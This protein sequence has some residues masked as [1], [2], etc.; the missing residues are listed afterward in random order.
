MVAVSVGRHSASPSSARRNSPLINGIN[1]SSWRPSLGV[2]LTSTGRGTEQAPLVGRVRVRVMPGSTPLC[3]SVP[4]QV[5][6]FRVPSCYDQEET[7][8]R[9]A[10]RKRE[11]RKSIEPTRIRKGRKHC[12]LWQTFMC[13]VFASLSA[14][15]S[16]IRGCVSCFSW[17]QLS[18]TVYQQASQVTQTVKTVLQLASPTPVPIPWRW[19]RSS[20]PKWFGSGKGVTT[21]DPSRGTQLTNAG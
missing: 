8:A 14:T 9:L 6:R 4:V 10:K 7:L 20:T 15:M 17:R 11:T 3:L 18:L 2:I 12:L 21:K 16:L 5:P 19:I 13:P 1:G